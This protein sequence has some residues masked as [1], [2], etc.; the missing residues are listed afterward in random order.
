MGSITGKIKFLLT[1]IPKYWNI[2]YYWYIALIDTL[3]VIEL[4]KIN[5]ISVWYGVLIYEWYRMTIILL[6]VSII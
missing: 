6:Y 1:L 3:S 4:I 2:V 5:F